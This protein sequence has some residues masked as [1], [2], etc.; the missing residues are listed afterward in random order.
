MT[1]QETRPTRD[2]PRTEGGRVAIVSGG[3]GGLGRAISAVLGQRGFHVALFDIDEESAL[4]Y[5]GEL[6]HAGVS[7]SGHR[8]DVCDASQVES[9][10][11]SVAA[12]Q[13]RIDSL[14]NLAGVIRNA[15]L[16][17]VT[18]AD[19]DL[20]LN[21]HALGTLHLMRAIAPKMKGAGYGRIVNMSSVAALGSVGGMSYGAAKGAIESMTRTAAL[22]LAR[23][24]VTVNCVAPGLVDAGM[25]R[26][27]PQHFQ[28]EG[29]ARIP[30]GR[31]ATPTEVA[32]AF[33]FL[34][35]ES[36]SYITGQ[37]LTVCGGLSVGF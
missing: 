36:S 10:V 18:D 29:I 25:F 17:N 1:V 12:S 21:T 22:E 26:T 11:M 19:F 20:T 8:V 35:S 32:A 31:P 23:H 27:T 16:Q 6:T 13:G 14:I 5:A 34:S 4:A 7:A 24:Q 9:A 15:S 30:L 3:A 33:D 2:D 37:V 28:D